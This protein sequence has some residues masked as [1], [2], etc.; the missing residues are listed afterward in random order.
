VL[1][2]RRPWNEGIEGKRLAPLHGSST[3]FEHERC[4]VFEPSMLVLSVSLVL[5]S[6]SKG[7]CVYGGRVEDKS[8]DS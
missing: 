7:S 1:G 8:H 2:Y 6:C 3:P 4:Q 5:E